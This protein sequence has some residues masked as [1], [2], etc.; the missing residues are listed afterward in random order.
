MGRIGEF[1][2]SMEKPFYYVDRWVNTTL[3]CM[4]VYETSPICIYDIC[5][6]WIREFMPD[7]DVWTGRHLWEGT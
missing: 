5:S 6:R 4:I 1:T 7:N 2:P 3:S